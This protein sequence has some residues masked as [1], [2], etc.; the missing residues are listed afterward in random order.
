[1]GDSVSDT[2]IFKLVFSDYSR[3]VIMLSNASDHLKKGSLEKILENFYQNT[4]PPSIS[5][6]FLIKYVL[7]YLWKSFTGMTVCGQINTR[8]IKATTCVLC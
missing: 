1:M 2:C 8:Q 3:E 4:K 5:N 7:V 6:F